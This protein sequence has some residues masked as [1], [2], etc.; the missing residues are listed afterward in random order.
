MIWRER[1]A[2][3]L[4]DQ[5]IEY[6][7]ILDL[8]MAADELRAQCPGRFQL[9][10]EHGDSLAWMDGLNQDAVSVVFE[11]DRERVEWLLKW[12]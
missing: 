2:T 12:G 7:N 5:M 3:I 10:W 8:N 4:W 9:Q 11:D 1:L 6:N